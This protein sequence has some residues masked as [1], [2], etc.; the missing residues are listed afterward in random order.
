MESQ[1]QNPEFRD[2]AENCLPCAISLTYIDLINI[3]HAKN[4]NDLHF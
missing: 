3:D 1:S 2:N 4:N